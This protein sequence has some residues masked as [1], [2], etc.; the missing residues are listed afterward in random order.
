VRFNSS[1]LQQPTKELSASHL[2][3]S[4]L[5][6]RS[7]EKGLLSAAAWTRMRVIE[8]KKDGTMEIERAHGLLSASLCSALL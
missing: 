6:L 1:L 3:L 8:M 7:E 5:K 4:E 2:L